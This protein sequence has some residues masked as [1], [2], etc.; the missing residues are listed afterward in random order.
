M[1]RIQFTVDEESVNYEDSLWNLL[2]R[3]Y[4]MSDSYVWILEV[5]FTVKILFV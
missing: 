3:M 5:E 1:H 4:L 2:V